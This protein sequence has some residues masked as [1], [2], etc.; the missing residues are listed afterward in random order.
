MPAALMTSDL[1][2]D[3]A[4]VP[5]L[6]GLALATEG[7]HVLVLGAARALFEVS[8]GQRGLARGEIRLDGRAPREALRAGALACAP[9]DPPLPASWTLLEYATWSA[10][11]AGRDR[12]TAPAHA[13]D[14]LERVRLASQA[15]TKVGSA[16]PAARRALVIA[17]AVATGASLLL[18]E[19]PLTG[20]PDDEASATLARAAAQAVSDR[21]SIVFAGRIPLASSLALAADE[22][23]VV[24][25]SQVVTRGAPAEIA[26]AAHTLSLRVLGDVEAFVRA[27]EGSGGKATAA[28]GQPEPRH[29]LL[30]LGGLSARDILRLASDSNSVVL[31][32]RPLAGAFA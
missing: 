8:A 16:L 10:R 26:A 27:V 4:G 11:L 9:L 32:L 31:E 12:A 28:A 1:R 19:D 17:G 24:D 21:R 23:I 2:V 15:R 20:L 7:D 14:A 6:D 5:A 18:L 3:V 22:A 25:G 30:E 13:A 29:V